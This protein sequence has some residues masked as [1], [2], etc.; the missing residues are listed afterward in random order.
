[1]K[2]FKSL[3]L[4]A[5]ILFTCSCSKKDN[6]EHKTISYENNLGYK[7][8]FTV[9][10]VEFKEFVDAD[11]VY[12]GVDFEVEIKNLMP[13]SSA[14]FSI[15]I[16]DFDFYFKNPQSVKK[17]IMYELESTSRIAN[18]SIPAESTLKIHYRVLY[19]TVSE[20]KDYVLKLCDT[21]I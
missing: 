3:F 5:I 18:V 15:N 12:D 16:D 10:N 20:N 14:G 19:T 13:K 17:V 4:I 7:L 1:M 8:E 21:R 6:F 2:I 11:V 9:K